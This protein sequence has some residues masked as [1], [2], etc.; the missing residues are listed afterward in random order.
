VMLL[1]TALLLPIM[2]DGVVSRLDGLLLVGML[3]AYL[4][5]VFKAVQEEDDEVIGEFE[6]YIAET[7][8]AQKSVWIDALLLCAGIAGLVLGAGAI[9]VSA[10]QMAEVLGIS[11]LGVGATIVAIG[12]SLPE[13]ATSVVAASRNEADIAVGNVIGSNVFNL[14][15]V[16]GITAVV[17]PVPVQ[18]V[19]MEVHFPAVMFMSVLLVPLVRAN[20][21]IRR[22]EGVILL[23]AY[24]GLA[25]W[26]WSSTVG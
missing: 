3:V 2:W 9:V 24:V 10:T 16:L 4:A 18:G 6:Q 25:T 11:G 21:Q 20:L 17:L 12:T 8:D 23:L 14:A 7:T 1:L 19:V 5:F 26:M 22:T 13:L 15:A